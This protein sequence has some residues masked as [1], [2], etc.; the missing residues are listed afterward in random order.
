MSARH[1]KL[2]PHHIDEHRWWYE[3]VHG[4]SVLCDDPIDRTTIVDIPWTEIRAAL[5]RKDRHTAK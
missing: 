5:N 1:L 2:E 3:D 4:I